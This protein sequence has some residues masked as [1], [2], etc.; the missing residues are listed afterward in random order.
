MLSRFLRCTFGEGTHC[1]LFGGSPERGVD[2]WQEMLE[3]QSKYQ[4]P[5]SHKKLT[6]II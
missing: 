2:L 6:T 4:R 1:D 3:L 5:R